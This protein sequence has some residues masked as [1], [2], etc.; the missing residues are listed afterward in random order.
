MRAKFIIL[1]PNIKKEIPK[2]IQEGTDNLGVPT[3]VQ[4]VKNPIA[5]G[6]VAVEATGSSPALCN[7]CSALKVPSGVANATA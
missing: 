3:M 4:W 5:A 2:F 7:R 1:S 6:W